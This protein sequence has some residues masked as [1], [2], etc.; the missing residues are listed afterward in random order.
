VVLSRFLRVLAFHNVWRANQA[1]TPAG[2]SGRFCDVLVFRPQPTKAIARPQNLDRTAV[3]V[4]SWRHRI[5]GVAGGAF[6]GRQAEA[7]TSVA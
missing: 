6:S 1:C 5:G 4:A 2:P 7:L 3:E